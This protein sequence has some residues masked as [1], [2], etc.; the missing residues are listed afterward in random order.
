MSDNIPKLFKLLNEIITEVGD[1]N[2]IEPYKLDSG[3][4]AD[5]FLIDDKTYATVHF[6]P[7]N[8]FSNKSPE[9]EFP[10]IID[11]NR[12]KVQITNIGYKIEGSTSQHYKTTPSTLFRILKTVALIV[13]RYAEE[14]PDEVLVVFEEDK[15][16]NVSAGQ[17]TKLYAQVIMKNLPPN[18]MSGTVK[19]TINNIEGIFICD[20]KYRVS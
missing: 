4:Y 19:D 3:G 18:F 13:E 6:D 20:K 10:P 17:K 7:V 16:G 11:I 15:F 12:D 14:W 8:S 9:I 2:N 1:L 5:S